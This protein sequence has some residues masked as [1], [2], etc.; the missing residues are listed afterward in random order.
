MRFI[1]TASFLF[2]NFFTIK[3]VVSR[4]KKDKEA[5]K[6]LQ[7]STNFD[8]YKISIL[9]TLVINLMKDA[10]VANVIKTPEETAYLLSRI[11][12]EALDNMSYENMS[13]QE[14]QAKFIAIYN[15]MTSTLK[16][17][18]QILHM[19]LCV[20]STCKRGHSSRMSSGV[21]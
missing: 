18:E 14:I 17:K 21:H 3:K 13:L 16:E 7:K 10:K 11:C 1:S 19:L 5:L 2:R 4:I 9:E 12:S 8:I 6:T 15:V 20:D